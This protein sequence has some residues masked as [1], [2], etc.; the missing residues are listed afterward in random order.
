MSEVFQRRQI[1]RLS[2]E[3]RVADIMEAAKAV[4]LE[5]GYDAALISEI[6]ARADVVEGTI[7]RYFENKRDLMIKVVERWYDE[8]LSDFDEQL[9]GIRGTWNRLRFMIWKHLATIERE[10]ALCRLVFQELRPG[11]EYRTTS[12][13]EL[14]QEYTKRTLEIVEQAMTSGEFR[15]DVPLRIVRDMI[16]GCVEH[17]TWGLIRG[18]GRVDIDRAA[19]VIAEMIYRGLAAVP[20]LPENPSAQLAERLDHIATRL[21]QLATAQDTTARR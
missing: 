11:P 7:Y 14:N 6:A 21:E 16:F 20:A 3:R 15:K 5:K 10:P 12:V 18:H 17:H 9:Q 1:F 19:D 8:M 4:F 13:F 2:R